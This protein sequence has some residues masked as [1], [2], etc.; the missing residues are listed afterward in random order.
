L[1]SIGGLGFGVALGGELKDLG[2][3]V[4]CGLGGCRDRVPPGRPL[5][6]KDI[7]QIL[8]VGSSLGT[9]VPWRSPSFSRNADLWLT[10]CVP[11]ELLFHVSGSTAKPAQP[12][13]LAEAGLT[14]RGDL[15]EWVLKN[16]QMLGNS[17]Q[18]VTFEFDRWGTAR[19]ENPRDRLDVLGLGADGRL[20][21]AELKRDVAP[22]TVYSQAIKYAAMAS[23][24]DDRTL[25][26]YHADYLTRQGIPTSGDGAWEQLL[27]H[28]PETN[29]STLRR[30]RIVLLARD[31]PPQVTAAAVWLNEMGL[32]LTLMRFQAYRADDRIL[33]TVSQLLPVPDV[34]EFTV[35]PLRAE[36]RSAADPV[37]IGQRQATATRRLYEAGAVEEGT[38]FTLRPRGEVPDSVRERLTA[39]VGENPD[40][41]TAVWHNDPNRPLRW[42]VDE[43]PYSPGGLVRAITLAAVGEEYWV[44]GTRW[45]VDPDGFDMVELAAELGGNRPELYQEFWAALLG[46]VAEA[47]P[48]WPR[49]SPSNRNWLTF[50]G[51]YAAA[52]WSIGF[53]SRNRLRSE[54]YLQ[55]ES[56]EEHYHALAALRVRVDAAYG[57][58][59][60]WEPLPGR[61]PSRVAD[62][63]EGIIERRGEHDHY[64]A[65]F[66]DSQER[67]RA[68][69][70]SVVT[71]VP[72]LRLCRARGQSAA[73]GSVS[74]SAAS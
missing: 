53:A 42:K 70:G 57:S 12:I 2:R 24:F 66:I 69:I 8:P 38:V 60:S 16:P 65:W 33:L 39:W 49:P 10:S 40:R 55:G 27:R 68:A 19:G 5:G 72:W 26:E 61:K 1:G 28:A 13:S 29:E 15:Q 3:W 4:I 64:V 45:W 31:F 43:Q 35:A 32:D 46:L 18:I 50:P 63:R 52:H 9:F 6:G 20:V 73:S 37:R 51:G 14:E 59:L 44:E 48:E 22:D 54:L 47:H 11:G 56:A 41:G 30:P 74:R 34:E 23:R 17:V 7:A 58:P 62:Y 36:A 71:L 21:V 25:G 67:L